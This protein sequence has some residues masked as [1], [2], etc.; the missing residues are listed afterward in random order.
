MTFKKTLLSLI[1]AVS[2]CLIPTIAFGQAYG[3]VTVE[4]LNMRSEPTTN[5]KNLGQLDKSDEVEIVRRVNDEWLEI[6][7]ANGGNAYAY[8]AYI[9]IVDAE[10]AING[11]GVRLRDYPNLT[12][13]TILKTL[14]N[15]DTVVIEYTVGD[16][17]KVIVAGKE[18]FVS[19]DYIQSSFLHAVPVKTL[20][21]VTR[22][23]PIQTTTAA[24]TTQES[25]KQTTPTQASTAS[26]RL[27]QRI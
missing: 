2:T 27:G 20:A 24:K 18:G 6:A 12:T 25:T 17:C 9:D 26:N 3:K 13:S 19:K 8:A 5:S 14:N 22:I 23:N 10:G 16:W 1:V 11:Q 7:T 21:R 4:T 15:R